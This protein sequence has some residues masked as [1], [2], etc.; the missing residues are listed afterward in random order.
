MEIKKGAVLYTGGGDLSGQLKYR[1]DIDGLRAIA[2]ISAVCFHAFP[3]WM[4]GGGFT[5]PEVFFVISGFLISAIIFKGLDN[6]TFSFQDFYARRIR[7][8]FPALLVVLAACLIL[9]W[10]VLLGDE[11]KAL[12]R[13][14]AA[15]AGFASN[16]VLWGE[17]GYFDSAADTKIL[18][19]LWTL[20]IEEQFYLVWP[21]LLWLSWKARVNLFVTTWVFLL[22]SFLLNIHLVN[23]DAVAA[24]YFPQARF[25]ELLSG[26][27]LAWLGVSGTSLSGGK[28]RLTEP[29]R[30]L[31]SNVESLLGAGLLFY[32]F[33]GI[34][35]TY[36]FPGYW[37][38]IPVL[39]TLLIIVAGP[40]AWFNRLVLSNRLMVGIGLISYPLYLWHWPLLTFVRLLNGETPDLS[41][42]AGVVCVA[43]FLAWLTYQFVEK[44]ARFG[45][46][47]RLK[48][49]AL[50]VAIVA[51]GCL[52]YGTYL[53]NGFEGRL[54][55]YADAA[56]SDLHRYVLFNNPHMWLD[57]RCKMAVGAQTAKGFICRITS[58]T[59]KTLIIG[60]SHAAQLA[61]D[62]I[63][64][65][66]NDIAL[67]AVNGCLPFEGV[68]TVKVIGGAVEDR[69]RC[70]LVTSTSLA[71][72]ERFPS[73]KNIVFA[74]RGMLYIEGK[75]FGYSERGFT[76]RI[77][78]DLEGPVSD[79]YAKFVAG[80]AAAINK[81]N[82][83][84]K[85][86]FF[87]EDVPE[88][89]VDVKACVEP[90]PLNFVKDVESK[91]QV[92]RKVFDQ[93]NAVYRQAVGSILK[94]V[95]GDVH[96]FSAYQSFCDEN[97]CSSVKNGIP[98]YCD[99]EHLSQMGSRL[100]FGRLLESLHGGG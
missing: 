46:A 38:L 12:G 30:Q 75:G 39:A 26:A 91:C 94:V 18:L 29:R 35:S 85:R 4:G 17:A 37:A 41:T 99:D 52:G 22:A 64:T 84:G 70:D 49:I 56:H 78:D 48:M 11:Y 57:D 3:E 36:A 55:N 83:L 45:G 24:F 16:F 54:Q 68:R 95:K 6:R 20:A 32:S 33:Y 65:E 79:G 53:K 88:I 67:V 25:W 100:V 74:T 69:P 19:H 77:E 10:Y 27:V 2:V 92:P 31:L 13:H 61:Y 59:P 81:F 50:V 73:I 15:G 96:V 43:L 40:Q 87:V 34:K 98:Y 86:V 66:A 82:A 9:G 47:L 71:L 1:P 90:R 5:G 28:L 51:V 60:D 8:V 80:Y 63:V 72:L 23:T 44:P 93:R 14:V 62:S 7:R 21:F 42:R 58:A 76:F 97:F 89:G